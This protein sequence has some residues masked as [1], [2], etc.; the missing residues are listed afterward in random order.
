MI[1][2]A[3]ISVLIQMILTLAMLRSESGVPLSG[4]LR[5]FRR[6][7][8]MCTTLTAAVGDGNIGVE[9]SGRMCNNMIQYMHAMLHARRQGKGLVKIYN[10]VTDHK[11][12][13]NLDDFAQ[14]VWGDAG[15]AVVDAKTLC[16]GEFASQS[17]LFLKRHRQLARCLF[18]PSVPSPKVGIRLGRADVVIH[19]RNPVADFESV[20][21]L[22]CD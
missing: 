5:T 22:Y 19:F 16:G 2:A 18:L 14:I 10:P 20:G 4:R 15:G 13:R 8:G 17:Y 21:N 11:Y 7:G 6:P 1:V 9:F 12:G 3:G